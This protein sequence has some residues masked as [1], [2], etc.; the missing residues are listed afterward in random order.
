MEL[1][2][3][4]RAELLRSNADAKHPFRFFYLA[5]QGA[6]PEVR[7]VVKRD[8]SH[9]DWSV[10]FYTDA[11]TPK[12]EQIKAEDKISALFYH[13]KK[14]LQ[15][16]MKGTAEL[17]G[18]ESEEYGRLLEKVRQSPAAKDYTSLQAP[19]SPMEDATTPRRGESLHFLAIRIR[20]VEL[21]ILQL[22]REEHVRMEY[23]LRDGAWTGQRVVP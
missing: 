7:T 2:D 8:F 19:G 14:Q 10:L 21:D 17:I 23:T 22:S 18:P 15:I 4:A 20:P 13:S 12:V 6:Y 16:R 11:R 5:T 3:L 1:L 9:E